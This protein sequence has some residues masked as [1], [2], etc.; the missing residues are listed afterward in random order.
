MTKTELLIITSSQLYIRKKRTTA[1]PYPRVIKGP[2]ETEEKR[3]RIESTN[4]KWVEREGGVA[5]AK[6]F[7]R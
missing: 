1:M 5:L 7:L 4:G 3:P 2:L 6:L